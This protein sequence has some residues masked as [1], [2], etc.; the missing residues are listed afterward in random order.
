MPMDHF[1]AKFSYR[2]GHNNLPFLHHGEAVRRLARKQD[3]LL[4]QN[5][6]Q[7][8]LPVEAN[9]D[10]FDFLDDGRLD[11]FVRFIE[12]DDLRIGGKRTRDRELLLLGT[13]KNAAGA[14]EIVHEIWKQ[15]RDQLRNLPLAVRARERAHQNIFPDGEI[16]NDLAALRNVGY[17]GAGAAESRMLSDFGSVETDLPFHPV[18]ETHQRFEQRGLSGAVAAEHCRHLPYRYIQANRMQNVAAVI[19]TVDV[20][21]LEHQPIPFD[22]R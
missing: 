20:S 22:P 21:Q 12:Q 3:I 15:L 4:N 9:D 14:L 11:A 16:G 8:D 5:D 7:A 17:A 1:I 19:I 6:R 13:G 10:G 18:G 2:A